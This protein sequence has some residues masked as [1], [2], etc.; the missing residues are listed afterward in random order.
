MAM[1]EGPDYWSSRFAKTRARLYWLTMAFYALVVCLLTIVTIKGEAV[2][3]PWKW[4][5]EL[6][7]FLVPDFPAKLVEIAT[8]YAGPALLLAAIAV[9]M[10]WMSR[11]I[12]IEEGECAFLS[13]A[14]YRADP[15]KRLSPDWK[16]ALGARAIAWI[17]PAFT[18]FAVVL[19]AVSLGLLVATICFALCSRS[20]DAA[21]SARAADAG[22]YNV[23]GSSSWRE[24]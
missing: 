10:A 15:P 3:P 12:R 6:A 20:A 18:V 2:E 1:L 13:W 4:P 16:P 19:A 14:T 23:V 7:R 22:I 5:A 8:T 11:R 21:P 17:G 9:L 24:R